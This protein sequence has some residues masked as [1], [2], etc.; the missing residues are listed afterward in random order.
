MPGRLNHYGEK[1][2]GH[3]RL[4]VEDDSSGKIFESIGKALSSPVRIKILKILK[5]KSMNI[6]EISD[7]IKIPVSSTAFHIKTLEDAG[8]IVT[9]S[10]PGIRGS[11]RVCSVCV[12]DIF[13]AMN[14]HKEPLGQQT[15]TVD[16]PIGHYFDCDIH[17]ACGLADVNGYIEVCDNPRAF[18]SPR[19]FSAQL[20]WFHKGY[21][22]YRFPNYFLEEKA[23]TSVAFSLELCSEAP[24]YRNVWPSDVTFSINGREVATYTSPGDYGGRHGKLTPSWWTDGNTQFGL[25]KTIGVN[26]SGS[27]LDEQFFENSVTLP[28][29]QLLSNSFISFRVEIKPNA[30]YVGGMNLFGEKFG[31]HAQNITMHIIC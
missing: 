18:Y 3:I 7:K 9:E 1:I 5:Y 26:P 25:L 27:F 6:V 11:Q 30:R 16:M 8:L 24:G 10:Q 13:I 21:I 14:T 15:F 17:P 23:P 28:E 29:L 4:D 22:E 12:D 2:N 31:D 19:R 20:I